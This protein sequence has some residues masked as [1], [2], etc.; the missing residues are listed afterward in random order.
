MKDITSKH[1]VLGVLLAGISSP[2]F[3]QRVKLVPVKV[4]ATQVTRRV[5]RA[6]P[7]QSAK[8]A[9]FDHSLGVRGFAMDPTRSVRE[10]D[11]LFGYG[12]YNPVLGYKTSFSAKNFSAVNDLATSPY[13]LSELGAAGIPVQFAPKVTQG[14][15]SLDTVVEFRSLT[16]A[17]LT[18]FI[19][20]WRL[21]NPDKMIA[22][23]SYL[24]KMA[25][26]K[27]QEA[28]NGIE[29]GFNSF[30]EEYPNILFLQRLLDPQFTPKTYAQLAMETQVYPKHV[31]LNESGIPVPT[32]E[33]EQAR[34][35]DNYLMLSHPQAMGQFN[36]ANVETGAIVGSYTPFIQTPEEHVSAEF[37]LELR[38]ATV[39]IPEHA[40]PRQLLEIAYNQLESHTLLYRSAPETIWYEAFPNYDKTL[41][42]KTIK[43]KLAEVDATVERESTDM[44]H[45][46]VLNAVMDGLDDFQDISA[47]STVM[48]SFEKLCRETPYTPENAAHLTQLHKSLLHA[49]GFWEYLP[50]GLGREDFY[51]LTDVE[52]ATQREAARRFAE[53][54]VEDLMHVK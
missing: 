50:D 14:E 41:L 15:A 20:M 51:K 10:F 7:T 2:L 34:L 8:G 16:V 23:E 30:A 47:I 4:P 39:R 5:A 29:T 32:P 43:S 9:K 6:V 17:Q 33:A 3:A 40:T 11:P 13:W 48:G 31:T 44:S 46:R 42:A 53:L 25:Q 37:L 54:S 52:L 21:A 49:S 24:Y 28:P 26:Q 1:L 38:Q 18:E 19:Y 22:E 12:T 35:L 27:V 36:S 45:L